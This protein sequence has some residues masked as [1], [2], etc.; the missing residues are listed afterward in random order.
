LTT[1]KVKAAEGSMVTFSGAVSAD[2]TVSG[3]MDFFDN[4]NPL[5][6]GVAVQ[7]GRAT[8]ATST[9]ALGT[10]PITASYSGDGHTDAV[11]TSNMLDQVITGGSQLQVTATSG[12]LTH[13]IVVQFSLN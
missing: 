11:Q 9:L 6:Q 3:T 10:H 12:S 8:Y 7:V 1:S 2:H 4:G 13:A 5:A